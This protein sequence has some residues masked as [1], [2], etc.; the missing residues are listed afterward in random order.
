MAWFRKEAMQEAA[1]CMRHSSPL[2]KYILYNW[3][4]WIICS[5]YCNYILEQ[6]L[7]HGISH[8]CKIVRNNRLPV[9]QYLRIFYLELT[10][11]K[12]ELTEISTVGTNR[13]NYSLFIEFSL[14]LHMSFA[15]AP[16]SQIIQVHG[17]RA[18]SLFRQDWLC[19]G[20]EHRGLTLLAQLPTETHL[21]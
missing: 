10:S 18:S 2:L 14:Q 13:D 12:W 19:K 3:I 8:L 16:A 7:I 6:D 21:S 5:L 9:L 1:V 4:V 15:G 17:V 11:K 20:S